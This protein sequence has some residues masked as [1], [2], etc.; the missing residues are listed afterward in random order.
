MLRIHKAL[1]SQTSGSASKQPVALGK[2]LHLSVP[3]LVHLLGQLGG[4]KE[5]KYMKCICNHC[6]WTDGS[7][8]DTLNGSR[9]LS[10]LG[11]HIW[12]GGRVGT[13]PPSPPAQQAQALG[14]IRAS[15]LQMRKLTQR[16]GGQ[17]PQAHKP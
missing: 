3:Q 12:P 2:L 16:E 5:F 9:S 7:Q 13:L 14:P 10:K 6:L 17:R 1:A 8:R 15:M 11:C 4:L